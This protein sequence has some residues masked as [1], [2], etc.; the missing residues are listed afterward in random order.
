MKGVKKEAGDLGILRGALLK[1]ADVAT[2]KEGVE[3]RHTELDNLLETIHL[4]GGE[5]DNEKL[6][7]DLG[8]DVREGVTD[9]DDDYFGG[10]AL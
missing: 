7:E 3:H 4:R 2:P 1:K 8:V 5:G 9:E 10:G 6:I